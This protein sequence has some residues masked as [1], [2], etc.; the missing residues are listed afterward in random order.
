MLSE[1]NLWLNVVLL[2]SVPWGTIQNTLQDPWWGGLRLLW[3]GHLGAGSWQGLLLPRRHCVWAQLSHLAL[4]DGLGI[5]SSLLRHPGKSKSHWPRALENLNW[6]CCWRSTK[7][8]GWWVEVL[9]GQD[10]K[11]DK[12]PQSDNHPRQSYQGPRADP[13][14]YASRTLVFF[15]TWEF[16]L[17]FSKLTTGW[18]IKLEYLLTNLRWKYSG[19][20]DQINTW[21]HITWAMQKVELSELSI[22]TLE[23][24]LMGL[25]LENRKLLKW[26][27]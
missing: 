26:G 13:L 12:L 4:D 3:E 23:D 20:G 22:L 14:P 1:Q 21:L 16:W 11:A 8:S 15:Q 5:T 10:G 9:Q 17:T 24:Y 7:G 2:L 19:P 6:T 27:H 18:C 25:E